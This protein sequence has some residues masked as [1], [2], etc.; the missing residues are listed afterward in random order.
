M[1]LYKDFSDANAQIYIWKY[2]ES[3]RLNADELLEEENY[4][5]IQGYHP[6]KVLETLM[7]R[8]I[9]KAYFPGYKILYNDR[10][11]YLYPGDFEISITHSFPYA[12]LAVSNN[13]IGIDLEAINP[14]VLKIKNKFVKEEEA[15]FIPKEKETDF[16]IMIWSV[17]ESLYKIH[18]SN[19]H[20]LKQ[21]YE[22]KPFDLSMLDNISCR[23]H[24]DCFSDEYTARIEIFDGYCFCVVD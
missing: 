9:L 16:L 8:K 18:H 17:K 5:K 22:V 24:D 14:K 2:D 20:S 3:E 21:H 11:P 15:L 6:K 4:A 23:V 10:E 13:K 1:P 7:V 12:A 19:Y